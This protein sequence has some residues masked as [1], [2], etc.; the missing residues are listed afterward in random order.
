MG[1]PWSGSGARNDGKDRRW[2][3]ALLNCL[4]NAMQWG[5]EGL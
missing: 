4:R 2:G 3:D 5:K 1:R